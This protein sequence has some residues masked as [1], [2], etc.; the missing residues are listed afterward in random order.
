M[1]IGLFD[2]GVGGL[3]IW[4]EFVQLVP[5]ADTVYVADQANVPY[6][7]RQLVEVKRLSEAIA[8]FLLDEGASM[9]VVACN[10]ASAAAL[11]HLR[12]VFPEVPCVGMEPALKPAV[13]QSR[14]G[15]VGVLATPATFHGEL[16]ASLVERYAGSARVVTQVC[17]GLVEAIEAGALDS[18]ET[19]ER[20]AQCIAPL[21]EADA[22]HLVLGCSH[23]PFVR[24]AIEEAAGP[25]VVI[26]DPSAAVAR[27]AASVLHSSRLACAARRSGDRAGRESSHLFF[28]TGEAPPF[29]RMLDRLVGPTVAGRKE[30]RE[31]RWSGDCLRAK[32]VD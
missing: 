26:V 8:R 25:D 22:D 19:K 14:S 32:G 29:A 1:S 31:A 7:T 17:P 15:V 11:H 30:V 13:A 6:G 24:S 20:I 10:T 5:D 28:T 18:Q 27:Q 16:F 3:S 9:V 21:I 12:E 2:S 23:Y 4:R